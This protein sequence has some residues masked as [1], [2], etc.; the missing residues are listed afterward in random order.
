MTIVAILFLVIVI[1]ILCLSTFL[2]LRGSYQYYKPTYNAI[3]NGDY[4]LDRK[5]S[6]SDT[7][8]FRRPDNNDPFT[9]DEIIFFDNGTGSIKLLTGNV[10]NSEYIHKSYFT[11]FDPYTLYWDRKIRRA[12][13][14]TKEKSLNS[15]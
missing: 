8:Y 4:I 12:F 2:T 9:H 11:Y 10:Y 15:L 13:Q 7:I 3:I 1:G 14:K 5:F 6:M